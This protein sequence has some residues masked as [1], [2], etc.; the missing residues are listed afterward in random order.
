MKVEGMLSL[1]KGKEIWGENEQCIKEDNRADQGR[2]VS[3]DPRDCQSR[4]RTSKL[5]K[6]FGK[7]GNIRNMDG[8]FRSRG[9]QES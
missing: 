1:Q 6:E 2:G 5:K 7:A 4:F 3:Q 8:A 9:V